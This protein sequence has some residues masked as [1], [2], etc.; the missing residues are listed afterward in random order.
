MLCNE[1]PESDLE[2]NDQDNCWVHGFMYE[3]E[4]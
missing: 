3:I 2:K 4:N 1:R